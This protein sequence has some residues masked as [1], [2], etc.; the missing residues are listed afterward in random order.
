M[1]TD[2]VALR[3]L[4]AELKRTPAN[5]CDIVM[6]TIEA[7]DGLIAMVERVCDENERLNG[8]IESARRRTSKTMEDAD[9]D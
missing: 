7:R 4:I 8:A 6:M 5:E 2:T 9:Y 1:P 3:S